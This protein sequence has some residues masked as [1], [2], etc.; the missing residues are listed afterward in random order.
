M[1]I[2][3]LK[4][5]LATN[6]MERSFDEG[7]IW[8]TIN[9]GHVL[10]NKKTG[11]ASAG[12]EHEEK[13]KPPGPREQ[14]V[15]NNFQLPAQKQA[16]NPAAVTSALNVKMP[17]AQ[18]ATPPASSPAPS[19]TAQ[20]IAG[21]ASALLGKIGQVASGGSKAGAAIQGLKDKAAGGQ[22][23]QPFQQ[24]GRGTPKD[25]E[26]ELKSSLGLGKLTVPVDPKTGQLDPHLQEA[27]KGAA[28]RMG[29]DVGEFKP[30]GPGR[31]VATVGRKGTGGD[32]QNPASPIS[33]PKTGSTPVSG[34]E[35]AGDQPGSATPSPIATVPELAH[36]PPPATPEES[37]LFDKKTG[38]TLPTEDPAKMAG[39]PGQPGSMNEPAGGL[40]QAAPAVQGAGGQESQ[41]PTNTPTGVPNAN[42]NAAGTQQAISADN[43]AGTGNAAAG[44][45]GLRQGGAPGVGGKDAGV[46]QGS[47]VA[48]PVPP[49]HHSHIAK[50]LDLHGK[51]MDHL[52]GSPPAPEEPV[53]V[54]QGEPAAQGEKIPPQ[55]T[56][57]AG[58]MP[59]SPELQPEAKKLPHEMSRQEW[60]SQPETL[61]A[62]SMGRQTIDQAI[63]E[64]K[65]KLSDAKDP[66]DATF[67]RMELRNAMEAKR[68]GVKDYDLG[69]ENPPEGYGRGE[70]GGKPVYFRDSHAAAIRKAGIKSNSAVS[71]P[72]AKET[73]N[74]GQEQSKAAPASPVSDLGRSAG[75]GSGR[76][77]DANPVQK[78][79]QPA[80]APAQAPMEQ[81][82]GGAGL[83]AR[84]REKRQSAA[85]GATEHKPFRENLA[86]AKTEAAAGK[87]AESKAGA[88][89]AKLKGKPAFRHSKAALERQMM[90][91]HKSAKDSGGQ[92][93]QDERDLSEASGNGHPFVFDPD[94]P[95]WGDVKKRFEKQPHIMRQF[96]TGKGGG[97]SDAV[98]ALGEKYYQIAERMA[99]G[100]KSAA[101]DA[102]SKSQ[103]PHD[104]LIHSIYGTMPE[105]GGTATGRASRVK[106][107]VK[108]TDSP[109][110]RAKKESEAA[111]KIANL[112]ARA[113]EIKAGAKK[114]EP[115]HPDEMHE[116]SQA[117]INDIPVR[118][119]RDEDEKLILKDGDDLP[120]TPV[121]AIRG[122]LPIDAGSLKHETEEDAMKGT[123]F[124]FGANAPEPEPESKPP[125]TIDP[126]RQF[127]LF[128]K[129]AEGKPVEIGEKAGQAN[130]F[131][132][133]AKPA[134]AAEPEKHVVGSKAANDPKNTQEMF[135]EKEERKTPQIDPDYQLPPKQQSAP[136]T[137]PPQGDLPSLTHESLMQE[138]NDLHPKANN[139]VGLPVHELRAHIHKKYGPRAA[140]HEFLDP[141]LRQ[142]RGKKLRLTSGGGFGFPTKYDL[143]PAQLD[144]SV[145]GA[146]DPY[147]GQQEH[148]SHL[149]PHVSQEQQAS[150]GARRG[151]SP[152]LSPAQSR[153]RELAKNAP[154]EEPDP[155]VAADMARVKARAQAK[156]KGTP[157]PASAA[158]PVK[159]KA[160]EPDASHIPPKVLAGINARAKEIVADAPP[161]KPITPHRAFEIAKAEVNDDTE[162]SYASGIGWLKSRIRG[163]R[164]ASVG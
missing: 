118:V 106:S 66:L 155:Q 71:Q 82:K 58:K 46:A 24:T 33:A 124:P 72:V 103:D 36:L 63:A 135:P 100:E 64:A 57:E 133:G 26:Q 148:L 65:Q 102:A 8:R 119:T 70:R 158:S 73:G 101:L 17:A 62:K 6:R 149:N 126:N 18:P 7:E 38:Q 2:P 3:E 21:G 42:P 87:P 160:S 157:T 142:L 145:K 22:P 15:M 32:Q 98:G 136:S 81:P 29:L 9:G 85:S 122:E 115:W 131:G 49:D 77:A 141:M 130:L 86:Q 50:M 97:G 75:L 11:H 28:Q 79:P 4:L 129:D 5:L 84:M 143:T 109:D 91:S 25:I 146:I 30:T 68:A 105:T 10:I 161:G 80:S 67:A 138:F 123:D 54:Q 107:G 151:E 154:R 19:S 20:P 113:G 47:S 164:Y 127:G 45:D 93:I 111:K 114:A 132:G 40:P 78:A 140:S 44:G 128:R 43:G 139:P 152:A 120:E 69:S 61:P 16:W 89:I 156:V 90:E 13:P 92:E 27:Y 117:T 53:T 34:K 137:P 150:P 94:S 121:D 56:E 51:M 112:R 35:N 31:A 153:I 39:M 134:P 108:P 76:A 162:N 88:A 55:P 74:A 96:R 116:G 12:M 1:T 99:G 23:M 52:A 95:A 48:S 104:R 110:V 41:V 14:A 125:Q 159:P 147:S 59:D 37:P 163:S 60:E 144:E 83:G